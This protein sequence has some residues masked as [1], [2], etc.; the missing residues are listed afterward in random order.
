MLEDLTPAAKIQAPKDW[1]PAVEF[2]GSVGEATLPA[3]ADNEKPDF[4]QFLIEAG[5]DPETIE[6]VGEPRTSRWQ[7]AR[8][9]PLEPQWL[10][11]Y[12][13]RFRKKVAATLDLP[14]LYAEVKKTKKPVIKET[15]SGQVLLLCLADFQIG[16]V[17]QRGGTKELVERVMA[18]YAEIE[19]FLKKNK[20]EKIYVLDMG[21]IIEGFENAASLQQLQSNDLS[22]MQQVD[23]AA[24]LVWDCLKMVTKYAPATYASIA[25]NHCQWRVSKQQ[26]GRPGKDDWGI[27]ILQQIRRLAVEVGLPIDFL[28]PQPHDE[29]LAFDAFGDGFHIVGLAHG[30]QYSRPENAITWWRNSTFGHQPVASAS[31][32]ITGHFHHLRV[33]EAGESHNGGSRYWVQAT[34]SDNGSGWFRRVAGEDSKTGISAIILKKEEFFTGSVIRF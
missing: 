30:H 15:E 19:A 26:V 24:A 1:K 14:T 21:D 32:L 2:D 9:Y 34:T 12:K 6:I 4:D 13:F 3:L 20:F 27:V 25:S 23:L 11:S 18:S 29:T 7:M 10:T 22:L 8:P 28:I 33:I 16:K 17:D 5:F 31:L